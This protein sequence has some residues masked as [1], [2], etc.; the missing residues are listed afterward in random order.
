M[1][2]STSL[3]TDGR[4]LRGVVRA[5]DGDGQFPTVIF[6]HGFTVD[7]VGMARLYELFARR[8]QEEGFVVIRFDFF[9]CGESDGDF[10]QMTIGSEMNE[11]KA[12]FDW[13]KQQPYVDKDRIFLAGHSMGGLLA[14]LMAP[15][16][17]PKGV[18]AWSPALIMYYEAARRAVSMMGPTDYG[19]DINGLELSEEY[20][21]EASRMNFIQMAAGYDGP[22]MIVH[23]ECDTEIPAAC[24]YRYRQLY[25]E[26]L[27]IHLV[28]GANHQFTSLPW[29]KELYDVSVDFLKE[30]T[31]QGR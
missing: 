25:E 29:K 23:G 6:M 28:K 2:L 13:A 9:G 31:T 26:K 24:A 20:L 21:K 8:C 10:R 16:L 3:E 27:C 12:I 4:L 1:Y 11:T 17:K 7:K 19:Y 5:P 15:I 30:Q 22:V 14:T 18:L